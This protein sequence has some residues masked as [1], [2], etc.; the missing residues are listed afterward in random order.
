MLDLSVFCQLC[1]QLTHRSEFLLLR[2]ELLL[3]VKLKKADAATYR[4]DTW[5]RQKRKKKLMGQTKTLVSK[6]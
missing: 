3:H 6:Y 4:N 2:Y 5:L 1:C